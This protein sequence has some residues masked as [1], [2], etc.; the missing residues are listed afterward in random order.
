MLRHDPGEDWKR[1]GEDP[2]YGVLSHDKFRIG[3]IDAKG[4]REFYLSG[5]VHISRVLKEAEID[6]PAT[7]DTE[8]K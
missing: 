2:F 5:E 8:E 7:G 1:L 6:L 4:I 3:N